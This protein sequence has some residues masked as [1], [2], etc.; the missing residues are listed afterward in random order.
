MSNDLRP[1]T[2]R[3][4]ELLV[5][6]LENGKPEARAFFP[7][8]Q[9]ILVTSSC[10][11]GCPSIGLSVRPEHAPA[12]TSERILVSAHSDSEKSCVGLILWPENGKLADLEVWEVG[13]DERPY[14]L[15]AIDSLC[16]QG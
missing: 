3:E 15:P 1:L 9:G 13:I 6:M 7:Q 5:W 12:Y 10:A 16:I 2:P 8:L 14:D 4:L 11:C